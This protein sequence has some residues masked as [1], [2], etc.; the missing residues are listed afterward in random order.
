MVP[1][2][3]E[4]S[5]PAVIHSW[6]KPVALP[7]Q[8]V[9]QYWKVLVRWF[10]LC[11]ARNIDFSYLWLHCTILLFFYQW[12]PFF[13]TRNFSHSHLQSAQLHLSSSVLTL[14]IHVGCGCSNA[15]HQ[16]VGQSLECTAISNTP[17]I[18]L[19]AKSG[20][21]LINKVGNLLKKFFIFI[22]IKSYKVW[23][24]VHTHKNVD[25]KC[26]YSSSDPKMI[27]KV[28]S[29]SVLTSPNKINLL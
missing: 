2:H 21:D 29:S 11:L 19:I 20:W 4:P 18:T 28:W 23:K 17:T 7:F 8:G 25:W 10:S 16:P 15:A 1:I 24:F 9:S 26:C 12:V 6:V 5:Y 22:R 3:P 27:A 14:I 13:Y